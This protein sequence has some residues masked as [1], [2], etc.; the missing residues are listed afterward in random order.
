MS[1]RDIYNDSL[2]YAIPA[3]DFI[4]FSV[5]GKKGLYTGKI[6]HSQLNE[7]VQ[8]SRFMGRTPPIF[9]ITY[10]KGYVSGFTSATC[11]RFATDIKK[12]KRFSRKFK[13]K[14]AYE[15]RRRKIATKKNIYILEEESIKY[16]KVFSVIISDVNSLKDR[17]Y[18]KL[19]D[20]QK[21]LYKGEYTDYYF[22]SFEQFKD[23][24]S[25]YIDPNGNLLFRLTFYYSDAFPDLA[26]D[27]IFTKNDSQKIL[28]KDYVLKTASFE[29]KEYVL[30]WY[31]F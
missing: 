27:K 7:S 18:P 17:L 19:S 11:S 2:N 23:K 15:H 8:F 25:Y 22:Q 6:D 4:V 5:E 31:K 30:T 20:M 1:I 26:S 13:N 14:T 28:G 29:N 21:K 12:I 9:I 24:K 16:N 3:N 10:N